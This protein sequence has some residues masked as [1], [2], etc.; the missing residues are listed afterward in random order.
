MC[1]REL[2]Q[3]I[4]QSEYEASMLK[5]Q[6]L[7]ANGAID[8]VKRDQEVEKLMKQVGVWGKGQGQKQTTPTA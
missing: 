5:L 7:D 1:K 4:S 8:P 2:R 3:E 6:R